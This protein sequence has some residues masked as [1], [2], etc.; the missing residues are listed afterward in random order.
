MEK[1]KLTT[2]AMLCLLLAGVLLN[3]Q[4]GVIILLRNPSF[5]DVISH[6]HTPRE[7]ID[8]GFPGE[9]EP[10]VHPSGEFGVTKLPLDGDTYL[11]MVARDNSTWERIGQ[12]LSAPMKRGTCY[13]FSIYLAKS[14]QY[15]SRSRTTD[16][17]INYI[18]NVKLRIYGGYHACQREQLLA[19]SP[20]ISSYDWQ[21]YNFRF[22]PENDYT[23]IT[24]EVFYQT[25]NLFPYNGNLLLD[26]AS[27][28]TPI[29]CEEPLPQGV[30]TTALGTPVD[31][32]YEK[33]IQ[34]FT[35]PPTP[36]LVKGELIPLKE[37]KFI[38]GRS[39]LTGTAMVRLEKLTELLIL[40]PTLVVE[41]NVH[42]NHHYD[43]VEAEDLTVKRAVAIEQFLEDQGV[44]KQRFKVYG[45]GN[46]RPANPKRLSDDDERVEVKVVEF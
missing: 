13:G 31:S 16:E 10:D 28:I 26:H 27:A 40:N 14:P 34:T 33:A 7:W 1:A 20:L 22:Q 41:I 37:I 9:T 35:P 3:A 2:V 39:E 38:T 15:L 17:N 18:K 23:Y 29:N 43:K 46:S 11:G 32:I 19:E 24:L 8:C 25:P 21:Q 12:H 6:S 36:K 5:E 44:N 30:Y 4:N 45:R 42:L